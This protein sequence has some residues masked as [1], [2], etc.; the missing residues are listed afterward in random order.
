M[1]S[2]ET[3]DYFLPENTFFQQ[4]YM[5]TL[6]LPDK[7]S[8]LSASVAA[9]SSSST[10]E[11][12]R[13]S[14]RLRDA[15]QGLLEERQAWMSTTTTQASSSKS[16]HPLYSK[17]FDT[18][19]ATE[20]LQADP[21][22]LQR[23]FDTAAQTILDALQQQQQ[24]PR[25]EEESSSVDDTVM[26]SD[27]PAQVQELLPDPNNFH[28]S[29]LEQMRVTSL[30]RAHDNKEYIKR[31][32]ALID[33][34][35][36]AAE[37]AAKEKAK[38][39]STTPNKPQQPPKSSPKAAAT[40]TATTSTTK[41]AATTHAKKK[42]D[43]GPTIHATTKKF[44]RNTPASSAESLNF[45]FTSS[46]AILCAAGNLAF[47]H[48]T[49]G[50]QLD[51]KAVP[52][53]PDATTF[54]A[55]SESN[56]NSN[57]NNT[58][59]MGAVVVE[60]KTLGQRTISV[61]ENAVRRADLRHQNR[62]DN[63]RCSRKNRHLLPV[64]NPFFECRRTYP[65][66]QQQ[67]QKTTTTPD[68]YDD[69]LL[70][71]NSMWSWDEEED[72][73]I[74]HQPNAASLTPQW[75]AHGRPRML[76]VLQR[77]AGHA[78]YYDLDWSSR[79]GRL[80]DLLRH[81]S[82][83]S[84]S[85][86]PHLMVTTQPEVVRF[87][88]EFYDLRGHLGLII[89][90]GNSNRQNMRVLAYQGTQQQRRRMRLC[91]PLATG[92]PES[93]FHVLV[94]SYA[95]FLQDYL[96]FC[97]LPFDTVVMDDG[98]RWMGAARGDANS[99]LRNIWDAAIFS[100]SD[101][102]IGL[103]GTSFAEWDYS[104]VDKIPDAIVKEAW[105]GLTARHRIVTASSF[106]TQ[107]TNGLEVVSVSG[108]VSFVL[109]HFADVVREEWDRSRIASDAQSMEHF[110]KLVARSVVVH[111]KTNHEPLDMY[112]LAV[113]GLT[114]KS[115]SANRTLDPQVPR[116]VPDEE[117]VSSGKIASSRRWLLAWFGAPK[118]SWMRY[119]L[120]NAKFEPILEIMKL[121]N[122]HG[123]FCE[124]IT[125][126]SSTTSSGASG[127]VA[128][129][130]AYRLAVRCGRHFGSEQGLRQHI[131]AMHAPPGT[132]LCRTCS[133]DCATSQ[134]R[135]HHERSC[136]LPAVG[137]VEGDNAS[138]TGGATP[139]VGQG[140]APKSGSGKK[141]GGR[142]G[143]SQQGP[144]GAEEKD[145][146]GS[147]RVPGYR[148]V[149]INKAGKHF[150]KINGRRL[151]ESKG[152][153]LFDSVDE[154]AKMYDEMVLKNEKKG[155]K[156]ELNFKPDGARIVYEDITPAT[157]SGLG[158]SAANVVPALSVIN[159]KDLPPSIK[160]LLRD[161]RQTSRTGGN[162]KRH[163]YA[164]RGVCR[165]ARKGHDRW[166]SQI[167]FMG[168]NHYLGTFD[169]EWDAA[170]VYAW[171][172]LILYGEEAT[173]QA[174]KEGEE[175]AASYE[176][177]KRD[178]AA[179][180]IPAPPAKPEKKTKV[181]ARKAFPKKTAKATNVK[182][183]ADDSAKG[184]IVKKKSVLPKK[185]KLNTEQV[186]GGGKKPREGSEKT[187]LLETSTAAKQKDTILSKGVSKVSHGLRTLQGSD[188]T[189]AHSL[190]LRRSQFCRVALCSRRSRILTS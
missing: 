86:G 125:T 2:A 114:G 44:T 120:A 116:I 141:K 39:Q 100:P 117:F 98:M 66:R 78:I 43:D 113:A 53:N 175:A 132:W 83:S 123:H 104:L 30:Q 79:H 56:N 19:G 101:E 45:R 180:K 47:G 11:Q 68:D 169:S 187:K 178:I 166:Q 106:S 118:R 29:K 97:Q 70:D 153:L 109:P 162:S 170:A 49:P 52:Q 182:E 84:S 62:Q 136:G 177:E 188:F 57:N 161:P 95:T 103:A 87:A 80:A 21:H 165:Q 1:N 75:E 137:T 33:P 82:S 76:Q 63:A 23:V 145:P 139:T 59:N 74:P 67:Q 134:A 88:Q 111:T 163:V 126:A 112:A 73:V 37:K 157:A 69:D 144:T 174:Q 20:R 158:G 110:R 138:G 135:T 152:A 102:H 107:R 4:I 160:P 60:A 34:D 48:L 148:G 35:V 167:S 159:I 164:Y 65:Q 133:T 36:Q 119:E 186:S 185:R 129:T 25:D 168:Q 156:V 38:Q 71:M 171:A 181:P 105:V 91:F 9:N 5:P 96:H 28:R 58:V 26:N 72:A 3:V 18:E 31:K 143:S 15:A 146:D 51:V 13:M 40:T 22:V 81:Y 92:L 179:G 46:R 90:T 16:I 17:R 173:R 190:L 183:G 14:W 176:Q 50:P 41:K 154:A 27:L 131:S 127:Q 89:T 99:S 93:P 61:A 8:A 42:D 128:G 12:R 7:K 115:G 6:L 55:S 150:L 140:A 32:G 64:S 121:S 142:S 94:T 122:K 108:L 184:T 130:M 124:E 155:E 151:A 85:F 54:A 10:E 149:W 77:G 172:H 147:F 24:Q 189:G